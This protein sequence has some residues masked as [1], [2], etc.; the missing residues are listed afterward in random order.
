MEKILNSNSFNVI[1]SPEDNRDYTLPKMSGELTDL[2]FTIG[3]NVGKHKVYDQGRTSMCT[4]FAV[5][6]AQ[7]YNDGND[8]R[9]SNAFLYGNREDTDAVYEGEYIRKVMKDWKD[10]GICYFDDFPLIG[11]IQECI[12][13]FDELP[14]DIMDYAKEHRISTFYR[15]NVRDMDSIFE[16]MEKF[17]LPLIAGIGIYQS[18]SESFKNGGYIPDVKEGENS[19][20]GHA[21]RLVGRHTKNGKRY[22]TMPNSWGTDID[23]NGVQFLPDTYPIFEVWLPIPY[24]KKEIS[25][26]IDSSIYKINGKETRMDTTPTIINDRTYLPLRYIVENFDALDVEWVQRLQMAKVSINGDVLSFKVGNDGFGSNLR[27]DKVPFEKDEDRQGL[28]RIFL[29]Q[30]DRLQIPIRALLE[31]LGLNVEWVE[32]TRE[33]VIRNY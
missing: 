32:E 3:G 25:F 24:V 23:T 20:G 19:L 30:N 12:K 14:Q 26:K 28:T 13:Q 27:M 21:V 17:E 33:V 4:S 31:F 7:E 29:D 22:F 8:K 5:A 18:I 1:P 9:F 6:C 16:V 11:T 15:L 10:D 2:D